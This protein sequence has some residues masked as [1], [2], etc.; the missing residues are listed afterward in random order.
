MKFERIVTA[1]AG[2]ALLLAVLDYL[3]GIKALGGDD[4][5]QTA[6]LL[7]VGVG[8]ASVLAPFDRGEHPARREHRP[9]EV[10]IP[11]VYVGPERRHG[12]IDRR[13]TRTGGRRATDR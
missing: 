6:M 5:I 10:N 1:A 3:F 7:T 13:T 8:L 2:V 11:G 4:V 9:A 12:V